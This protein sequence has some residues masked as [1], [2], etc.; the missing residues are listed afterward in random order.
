MHILFKQSLLSVF[1]VIKNDNSEMIWICLLGFVGLLG[2][3]NTLVRIVGVSE[4]TEIL[5]IFSFLSR[6]P[7][8]S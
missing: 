6:P 8:T 7:I 4:V 3:R 5:Q 1:F 2:Q